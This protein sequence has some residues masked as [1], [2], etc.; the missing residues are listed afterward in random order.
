MK[1]KTFSEEL[2]RYE[3]VENEAFGLFSS[4]IVQRYSISIS[5]DMAMKYLPDDELVNRQ[6]IPLPIIVDK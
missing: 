3:E 4:R 2:G 5:E 6:F 1:T